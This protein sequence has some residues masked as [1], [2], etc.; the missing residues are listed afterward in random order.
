MKKIGLLI[1]AIVLLSCDDGNID[2]PEFGFEGAITSCGELVLY[3]VNGSETLSLELSQNTD[4]LTTE[5]T[6]A[7]E[8]ILEEDGSNTL[9]YRTF[10]ANVTGSTYF[11]QDIPPTTPNILNEW[12]G[13]GILQITTVLTFDDEDGVDEA[14]DDTI[15]TD[16]DGTPNYLDRDDDG[17][18]ILTI[19]EDVD[20]DG[21]PTNDDT[22]GDTIPN[23]LDE[24]DDGDGVNTNEEDDDG[25]INT[26]TDTD[27]DEIAN[28]L[29]ADDAVIFTT[30]LPELDEL[31][32]EIYNSDLTIL[33][34]ELSNANGN[35]IRLE[36][37]DFGSITATKTLP[38]TTI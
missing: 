4:F 19:N 18:G 15:D 20:G 11:C 29:D 35:D 5:R 34:L 31:Y 21:D 17:D 9:I 3:K 10:D 2:V 33:T 26:S 1:A 36:S 14:V 13:S 7:Q 27:G 12:K 22:D 23:Y 24:D 6:T 38:E 16:G 8:I 37:F 30:M 32:K 28:Y 25:N